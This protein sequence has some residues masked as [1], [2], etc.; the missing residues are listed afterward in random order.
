[1]RGGRKLRLRLRSLFER[2]RVESELEDELADY[3]ERETEEYVRRGVTPEEAKRLARMS[4][5][6]TERLKEECRDAR[7]RAGWKMR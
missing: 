4:V 5:Y 2:S 1:M 6:G 3:L 7:K